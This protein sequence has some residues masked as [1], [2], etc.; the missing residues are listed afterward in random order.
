M[1]FA[2]RW[3]QFNTGDELFNNF[4]EVL[5]DSGANRWQNLIVSVAAVDRDDIRFNQEYG[6]LLDRYATNQ[7]RDIMKDYLRSDEV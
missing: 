5:T 2:T 7:G 4:E 1:L 3:L 6:N